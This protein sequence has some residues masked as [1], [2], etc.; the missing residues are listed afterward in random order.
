[1][2]AALFMSLFLSLFPYQILPLTLNQYFNTHVVIWAMMVVL[3]Y[4]F[5]KIRRVDPGFVPCNSDAYHQ[6]LEEVSSST[7]FCGI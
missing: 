3:W 4:A 6:R 5:W 7:V 1:M 2:V